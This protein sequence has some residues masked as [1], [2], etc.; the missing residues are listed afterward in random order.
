MLA[1]RENS[2]SCEFC[3]SALA[4]MY[5]YVSQKTNPNSSSC[6]V[7]SNVMCAVIGFSTP[8]MTRGFD[9]QVNVTLVDETVPLP[10]VGDDI[11]A[12]TGLSIFCKDK[13]ALPRIVKAGDILTCHRVAI[14]VL[15]DATVH[16]YILA[17]FS[18][19]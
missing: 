6:F 2:L 4:I 10:A 12:A 15:S 1:R 9:Y 13:D 11:V 7:V 18:H 16:G 17:H 8:T 14:Q 5:G 19:H 3:F